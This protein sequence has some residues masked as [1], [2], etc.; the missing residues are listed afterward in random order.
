MTERSPILYVSLYLSV[1]IMHAGTATGLMLVKSLMTPEPSSSYIILN[2]MLMA[3]K[4][5]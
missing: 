1:I 5:H 2:I 4:T 3:E